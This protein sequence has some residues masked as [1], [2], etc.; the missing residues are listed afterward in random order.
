MGVKAFDVMSL[1]KAN[2]MNPEQLGYQDSIDII[3]DELHRTKRS[4][5]KIGWYLKHILNNNM[6]IEDGYA[7]IYEFASDKFN[8]SQATATRF[9]QV[10]EQFSVGHDSPELDEK[11]ADFNMSQLFEM[12]PMNEEDMG[13]VTPDMKVADIRQF[14]KKCKESSADVENNEDIPGQTSIEKDFKEFMPDS[15]QNKIP[16]SNDDGDEN[17][18]Y[19]ISHKDVKEGESQQETSSSGQEDKIID[20]EY[21]EINE[22]LVE[23]NMVMTQPD[24]E[25]HKE[26]EAVSEFILAEKSGSNN[27]PK[28]CITG[29]SRYE[30]C[31]C[32]GNGGVQCCN[33]CNESCNSRCGWID[34]PYNPEDEYKEVSEQIPESGLMVTKRILE[35]EK[36]LLNDYLE[37]GGL[38]EMT[39]L[40]Q[41]TIVG[42]LAVM[43]CD[44]ED[45]EQETEMPEEQPE[46]PILKN[47]D[48]RKE[49]LN[50]YKAWGLWYR[51][52]KIDIN[53][54]KYDFSDGSRLVVTEYPQRQS[55]WNKNKIEDEHFYHL[56]QINKEGYKFRYNEKFRNSIDSETYIIDFLKNL[57]KRGQ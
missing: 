14:K 47:N 16:D 52:E 35:Q 12:L 53:Y 37:A 27:I 7:N 46:L 1:G 22:S 6:Y 2:L 23:E 26:K 15:N 40:R 45:E 30:A 43:V 24:F 8:L 55:Y 21:R 11:Y 5:V 39:V 3:R 28:K 13:Q 33:Q 25:V 49:W 56:L 51:D 57:Q 17:N 44:L 4:F 48:Q 34:E 54:Y 20:G 50:N 36:K 29:W 9:M 42:A 10:C 32:C 31:N 41:K 38:P 19:V 18:S